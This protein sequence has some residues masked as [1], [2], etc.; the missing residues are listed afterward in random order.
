MIRDFYINLKPFW[1]IYLILFLLSTI[2]G[3][4]LSKDFDIIWTWI[5]LFYMPFSLYLV[6]PYGF[7]MGIWTQGKLRGRTKEILL[8]SIIYFILILLLLMSSGIDGM[9]K[10]GIL[11]HIEIKLYPALG[12]TLLFALGAFIVKFK[13]HFQTPK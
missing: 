5:V 12:S 4:F 1:I 8:V 3:F 13:Q 2:G 10:N 11:Y 9:I 7:I 6:Y